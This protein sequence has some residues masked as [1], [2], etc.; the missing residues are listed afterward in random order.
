VASSV[1]FASTRTDQPDVISGLYDNAGK[2]KLPIEALSEGVPV[3]AFV[4]C[5]VSWYYVHAQH[6]PSSTQPD[7]TSQ[8]VSASTAYAGSPTIGYPLMF[9]GN[10]SY[11]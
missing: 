2:L 7:T 4:Q 9:D 1:Q 11:S 5:I 6:A 10:Y 8:G 3:S